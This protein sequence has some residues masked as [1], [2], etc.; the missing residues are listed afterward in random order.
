M[1]DS[2]G[3]TINYVIIWSIIITGLVLFIINFAEMLRFKWYIDYFKAHDKIC[4]TRYEIESYRYR[5]YSFLYNIND[6][7]YSTIYENY[8][9]TYIIFITYLTCFVIV[10][11]YISYHNKSYTS[12]YVYAFFIIMWI[13]Y[14]TVN[15]LILDSF[16]KI[17]QHINNNEKYLYRYSV[18]YKILNA[19]MTIS[20]LKDTN[21]QFSFDK[22][23]KNDTLDTIIEKNIG[24]YENIINLSKIRNIKK[25][26]YQNLDFVKYLVLDKMSPYYLKYFDNV[27]IRLPENATNVFSNSENTYLKD[28]YVNRVFSIDYID[29]KKQINSINTKIDEQKAYTNNV[30]QVIYDTI[31]NSYPIDTIDKTS[32]INNILKLCDDLK[33]VFYTDK[34]LPKYNNELYEFVNKTLN[35]IQVIVNTFGLSDTYK[36][37]NML[38]QQEIKGKNN[39]NYEVPND[40]YIEYFLENKDMVMEDK[41]T[42]YD[43]FVAQFDNHN[44]YVYSYLVYLVI[45]LMFILHSIYVYNNNGTY[46]IIV[47]ILLILYFVI[48][49]LYSY[50]KFAKE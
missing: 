25:E 11:F 2:M 44:K 32:Y 33:K 23:N 8:K 49:R 4:S 18:I 34:S 38:I 29:L 50:F 26:A 15:G 3:I 14:T 24:N 12:L 13:V 46:A 37:I 21:L 7:I 39:I 45:I 43:E 40:D 1:M 48:M 42:M 31:K 9:N 16:N 27:Y 6:T 30:Y 20:N 41:N 5:L 22:F 10:F 47:C 19:I 28:L 35:N 17:N 36:N